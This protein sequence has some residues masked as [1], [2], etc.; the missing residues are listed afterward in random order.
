MEILYVIFSLIY[1]SSYDGF[2]GI[3]LLTVIAIFV[4]ANL[5][6]KIIKKVISMQDTQP[7]FKLLSNGKD[8]YNKLQGLKNYI[9]KFSALNNKRSEELR[10]WDDYLIYSVMFGF[11]KKIINE[12]SKMIKIP[13]DISLTSN[14]DKY[15]I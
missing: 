9:K 13:T 5:I 11:N 3:I 12:Y 1:D 4:I 14:S 6:A 8:I 10:L 15:K 2:E 7:H